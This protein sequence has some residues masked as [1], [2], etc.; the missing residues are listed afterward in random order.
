MP[1]AEERAWAE[2]V[3]AADREGGAV[4]VDGAMVDAPVRLR[5]EA[6]MHRV[7]AGEGRSR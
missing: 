6:I 5:A 7:A 3:L 2:R 1:S 4:A